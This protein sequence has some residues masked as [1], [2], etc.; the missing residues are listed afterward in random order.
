M[1]AIVIGL[2]DLTERFMFFIIGLGFEVTFLAMSRRH[3][4]SA[5]RRELLFAID[6]QGVYLGPDDFGRPATRE[7]WSNIDFIIHFKGLIWTTSTRGRP[8]RN[9]GIVQGGRIVQSRA[10][11]G[12]WFNVRRAAAA[13]DHF[14]GGTPVLKGPYFDQVPREWFHTITLPTEWLADHAGSRAG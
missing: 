12:W 6:E 1:T 7:S 5:L 4:L 13:A 14:G 10:I 3:V 11:G 9:V 2:Q 8:N